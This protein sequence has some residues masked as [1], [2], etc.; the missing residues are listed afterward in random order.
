MLG[1]KLVLQVKFSV[2]RKIVAKY[3]SFQPG[4]FASPHL[5]GC[6]LCS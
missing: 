1:S 3:L 2:L 5:C 4:D 6:A